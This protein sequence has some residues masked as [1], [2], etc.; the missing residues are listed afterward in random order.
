MNKFVTELEDVEI[1][2]AED[3][4]KHGSHNQ[5]THG[6]W[7]SGGEGQKITGLIDELV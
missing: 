3:V 7:A 2:R 1:I 6:N 4:S 5:S